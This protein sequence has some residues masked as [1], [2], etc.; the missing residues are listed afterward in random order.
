MHHH[1]RAFVAVLSALELLEHQGHRVVL[2]VPIVVHE[3]FL[4]EVETLAGFS[5]MLLSYVLG[6]VSETGLFEEVILGALVKTRI[7]VVEV[8]VQELHRLFVVSD[9]ELV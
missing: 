8:S 3:A 2:I 1:S 6:S 4:D 7:F 5:L 9:A